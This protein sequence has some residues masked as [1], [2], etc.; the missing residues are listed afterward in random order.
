MCRNSLDN[1]HLWVHPYFSS[2]T[3]LI[4]FIWLEWFVRWEVSGRTAAFLLHVA[5]RI[6]FEQHAEFCVDPIYFFFFSKLF[7]KVLVVSLC[8]STDT[9]TAWEKSCFI[10][11]ERSDLHLIDSASIAVHT[12]PTHILTSLSIDEMLLTKYV[13]SSTNFRDLLFNVEVVHYCLKCLHRLED[14]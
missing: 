7:I 14:H 6:C 4:L 13:N 8:N 9:A 5:S 3:Q 12:F 11:S 1:Y 2:S 10:S